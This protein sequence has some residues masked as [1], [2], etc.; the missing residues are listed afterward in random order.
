MDNLVDADI[1]E[2]DR[3]VPPLNVN[4]RKHP[5]RIASTSDPQRFVFPKMDRALDVLP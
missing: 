2:E 5:F 1:V 3:D 4:T